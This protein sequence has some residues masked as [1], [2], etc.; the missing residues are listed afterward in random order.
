[1][2]LTPAAAAASGTLRTLLQNVVAERVESG[3]QVEISARSAA[4]VSNY[5]N[6][7]V[8]NCD[9][10]PVKWSVHWLV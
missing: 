5:D 6:V 3:R 7:H 2:L 9:L 4:A 1:M 10:D 8:Q